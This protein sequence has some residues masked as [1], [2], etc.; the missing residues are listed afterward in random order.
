M[1]TLTASAAIAICLGLTA[2]A[3]GTG[4]NGLSRSEPVDRDVDYVKVAAVTQ[5]AQQRG[6]TVVWLNYPVVPA[7]AKPDQG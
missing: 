1:K 4:P 6:A 7:R 2:C 5:W 3:G